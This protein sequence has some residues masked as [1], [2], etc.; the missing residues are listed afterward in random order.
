MDPQISI[1]IIDL[2][3]K[4][5]NYY[6]KNP[7][8]KNAFQRSVT[9]LSFVS[10]FHQQIQ[11]LTINH[12]VLFPFEENDYENAVIE[13]KKTYLNDK[14][15]LGE[16]A[17]VHIDLSFVFSKEIIKYSSDCQFMLNIILDKSLPDTLPSITV[18]SML[19]ANKCRIDR[20]NRIFELFCEKYHENHDFLFNLMFHM[21][22]FV[23]YLFQINADDMIFRLNETAKLILELVTKPI[24]PLPKDDYYWSMQ[25][26][27][28]KERPLNEQII[29]DELKKINNDKMVAVELDEN[30]IR[31]AIGDSSIVPPL[32]ST[33]FDYTVY[34][35]KTMMSCRKNAEID[36][37]PMNSRYFFYKFGDLLFHS[38]FYEHIGYDKKQGEQYR[39]SQ[40]EY[41]F[42]LLA[43]RLRDLYPEFQSNMEYIL[44]KIQEIIEDKIYNIIN[45]KRFFS[46][47]HHIESKWLKSDKSTEE[48]VM[49][50]KLSIRI[51]KENLPKKEQNMASLGQICWLECFLDDSICIE[52][53]KISRI[54]ISMVE[55]LNLLH[56]NN[57]F[58]GHF[59]R[60]KIYIGQHGDLKLYDA[61]LETFI[62][63]LIPIIV[64]SLIGDHERGI[65]KIDL[66]EF[67]ENFHMSH[68]YANEIFNFGAFV[69]AIHTDFDINPL[70]PT[71]DHDIDNENKIRSKKNLK[72]IPMTRDP[73]F[74]SLLNLILLCMA[75][76]HNKRPTIKAA[77]S[78]LKSEFIVHESIGQ[79]GFGFVLRALNKLDDSTYAIKIVKFREN[80]AKHV[81]NEVHHL[82]RLNH[83]NVVRY[84]SSWI[85]DTKFEDFENDLNLSCLDDQS[86]DSIITIDSPSNKMI[87]K[88]VLCIQMELCSS[89]TLNNLIKSNK[90]QKETNLR[91]KIFKQI[92]DA[93]QYIHCLGIV[94]RDL[95]PSNIFFDGEYN[96]KVGDFGLAKLDLVPVSTNNEKST[97]QQCSRNSSSYN[98]GTYLYMA[99]E[100]RNLGA[101][102]PDFKID[103]FA[104]GLIYFEMCYFMKTDSERIRLLNKFQNRT[105]EILKTVVKNIDPN[106]WN[107]I[108]LMTSFDPIKRPTAK[109]LIEIMQDLKFL[110]TSITNKNYSVLDNL[111][112]T[113]Y[114]EL[115]SKIFESNN[116]TQEDIVYD[117]RANINPRNVWSEDEFNYK[118]VFLNFAKWTLEL[119]SL[120]FGAVQMPIP[121]V[122]AKNFLQ[123]QPGDRSVSLIDRKGTHIVLPDH[124]RGI[125]ARY[126]ASNPH[127]TLLRRFCIEKS[128]VRDIQS[129]NCFSHC[130]ESTLDLIFPDTCQSS[131]I[132]PYVEI[133]G[134][135]LQI[136]PTFLPKFSHHSSRNSCSIKP[137]V[138]IVVSKDLVLKYDHSSYKFQ[139]HLTN[140]NIFSM[141]FEQ[142]E[143]PQDNFTSLI[144]LLSHS[145]DLRANKTEFTIGINTMFP[146][147]N[148]SQSEILFDLFNLCETSAINLYNKIRLI[149]IKYSIGDESS[150]STLENRVKP[151]IIEM[152]TIQLLSRTYFVIKLIWNLMICLNSNSVCYIYHLILI[153]I[154]TLLLIYCWQAM[155]QNMKR[156]YAVGISIKFDLLIECMKLSILSQLN[157]PFDFDHSYN[158]MLNY[159]LQKIVANSCTGSRFSITDIIVIP[160]IVQSNQTNSNELKYPL[161]KVCKF[162]HKLRNDGYSTSVVAHTIVMNFD[163]KMVAKSNYFTDI[164]ENAKYQAIQL[165]V[166]MQINDDGSEIIYWLNKIENRLIIGRNVF[167]IKCL[168]LESTIGKISELLTYDQISAERYVG[169]SEKPSQKQTNQSI[170]T[171]KTSRNIQ[172][173]YLSS[174]PES[175]ADDRRRHNI[176]HTE[177]QKI[178]SNLSLAS[179]IE[180]IT[181]G[182]DRRR[183]W[184]SLNAEIQK[185]GTI[186]NLSNPN[187]KILAVEFPFSTVKKIAKLID[188]DNLNSRTVDVIM[189]QNIIN[190]KQSL[191][192]SYR[193]FSD[194]IDKTIKAICNFF[195]KNTSRSGGGGGGGNNMNGAIIIL[196]TFSDR[197]QYQLINSN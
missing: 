115:I 163:E 47:Y 180:F 66:D 195:S 24:D 48:K 102:K 74:K 9:I 118:L 152:E 122:M 166:V 54:V 139:I 17:P 107:L 69:L 132:L 76:D 192:E 148:S 28:E 70:P 126:L 44:K 124:H 2:L 82:S 95:K 85:D 32:K 184:T 113:R 156:L 49:P 63:N 142:M 136:L 68:I 109:E 14:Q 172:Q 187:L 84:Y 59:D 33:E 114:R 30:T 155:M 108:K 160:Y 29:N 181:N 36:L 170:T 131:W 88:K 39:Y 161:D 38:V 10:S 153:I 147:I 62:T 22:L 21:N 119:H 174:Q 99:P 78:R 116:R 25:Q 143:L 55:S 196:I 134:F 138:D 157:T 8:K 197:Y 83:P 64:R 185:L 162:I 104:L 159:R 144:H 52:D 42:S 35:G 175:I 158:Q 43:R 182:T 146:Q 87:P 149:F 18:T 79:G 183:H 98:L 145:H 128:F 188:I 125:L 90:I 164:Y 194:S 3:N 100:S 71:I 16:F 121:I 101:Y 15:K 50:T 117:F 177:L 26:I 23:K 178:S 165:I 123:N 96:V 186:L 51:A 92:C 106:D 13:M 93:I 193:L 167:Q 56:E 140:L 91:S 77:T 75:S 86:D 5:K 40:F 37:I 173:T 6:E 105:C 112:S 151:H 176:L 89:T 80:Q 189:N 34:S 11:K 67:C 60:E 127:I 72:L 141:I 154:T 179:Q 41:D 129:V 171:N 168:T 150:L 45:R 61:F 65:R 1:H 46:D 81:M 20:L 7:K 73:D 103:I 31:S 169:I 137:Y 53:S 58:Y 12:E 135:A 120:L 97:P 111:D 110:M 4:L 130:N 27:L 19:P 191:K 57:M 94:H 190:I 133:I